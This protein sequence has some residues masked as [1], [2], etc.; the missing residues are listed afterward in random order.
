VGLAAGLA[1]STAWW[2]RE[3]PPQLV[4]V[5]A[6]GSALVGALVVTPVL[7][8][9]A[10]TG[11]LVLT[12]TVWGTG[13]VHDEWPVLLALCCAAALGA[14]GGRVAAVLGVPVLAG[15][16]V[17]VG[18]HGGP[19]LLF[20][21][22]VLGAVA[23]LGRL[24]AHARRQE[25]QAVGRAEQLARAVP[26]DLARRA[27][28]EERSRLAADVQVV[29]RRAVERM[30][31]LAAEAERTWEV[32]PRPAL[33]QVQVEGRSATIEL[34]R[35][36]GLLRATGRPAHGSTAG[37]RETPHRAPPTWAALARVPRRDV[38]LG[39][40]TAA[41]AA[42]ETRLYGEEVL[43]GSA[44]PASLLL[45]MAA[46][47]LLALRT[48]AP[49]TGAASCGALFTVAALAGTP[50]TSGFWVL[51]TC[52]GLAW[53]SAVQ[54]SAP[55]TAAWLLLAAGVGVGQ[56]VGSPDNAA[57]SVGTVLVAGTTGWWSGGRHRHAERSWSTAA[58]LT[59]A[60]A[61]T[62]ARAVR[63]DRVALA[64]ELHDAVSGAVGVMVVQAGAADSLRDLDPAAA[65]S[66]LR[67]V[68][69][70]A[71]ATLEDMDRWLAV[72]GVHPA[73][74]TPG[75]PGARGATAVHELVE[76]MRAA[77][78]PVELDVRG[79][80]PSGDGDAVYRI[81]QEA[82][83]NALRHAPGAHVRVT[84]ASG[85]T[86]TEVLVEDDGPGP[87]PGSRPGYGLVGLTERVERLG[88]SLTSGRP[89][90]GPGF[91]VRARLPARQ[92]AAP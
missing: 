34:R 42:L 59:A 3:Q 92:G 86:A 48:T 10:A 32:D 44:G 9:T 64:R 73:P 39:A 1:A 54:R 43:G 6:A 37:G 83:T 50:L 58:R 74:A 7:A 49:V 21:S 47:A 82:L 66:A 91:A 56:A 67:V 20:G 5:A 88:G 87:V 90:A 13:E 46:A 79:Q 40:A 38:A 27:V 25:Q 80:W 51:A 78:M 76:R 41:L 11:L 60:H 22:V 2:L 84:V 45:T 14:G 26:E 23:A 77:G 57:I 18:G 75:G 52:G 28:A 36:L 72:A 55:G 4:T 17:A 85:P 62:A 70:M 68:Q 16:T 81:V 15:A 61:D 19:E 29:V 12:A 65:R 63:D 24:G 30:A 53:A 8:T 69:E 89:A 33:H 71:R 35:M 31:V